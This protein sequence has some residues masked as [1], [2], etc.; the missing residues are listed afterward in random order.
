MQLGA[1][2]QREERKGRNIL[3]ASPRPHVIL[4]ALPFGVSEWIIDVQG[5][6]ESLSQEEEEVCSV[7]YL[8]FDGGT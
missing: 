6:D 4:I 7:F 8:Q 2:V 1:T 3:S 5:W